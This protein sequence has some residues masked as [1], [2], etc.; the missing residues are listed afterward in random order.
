MPGSTLTLMVVVCHPCRRD[1]LHLKNGNTPGLLCV[2]GE[3]A[4]LWGSLNYLG[5]AC[6]MNFLCGHGDWSSLSCTNVGSIPLLPF[7]TFRLFM[8]WLV[9]T[10]A[11]NGSGIIATITT[12]SSMMFLGIS[13]LG[14]TSWLGFT[15]M[16]IGGSQ[17]IGIQ[18][19]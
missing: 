10:K 2:P 15:V 3:F 1:Y 13:R 18:S 4:G 17:Q 5:H 14:G 19:C 6:I 16:T 12:S 8:P 9:A 7:R 11:H